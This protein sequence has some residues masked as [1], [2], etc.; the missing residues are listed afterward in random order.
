LA[1]NPEQL[2]AV[3]LRE[4][5]VNLVAVP[6]SGKTSVFSKRAAALL[7][8]VGPRRFLGVT[9]TKSAAEEFEHR[10]GYRSDPQNGKP[11]VFRTFHGF[12]LEVASKEF[13]NFPFTVQSHPLLLPHDQY[14][15]LGPVLKQMNRRR[16]YKEVQSYISQCKRLNISPEQA[17]EDAEGDDAVDYAHAYERYE[18][19]CMAMGKF[20]FDSLLIHTVKLLESRPEILARWQPDFL[21]C[22]EAQDNDALQW[23]LVELLGAK[24]NVFVVGDPN[25]NMYTWRG[26]DALGLTE[27]FSERWPGAK[28]LSLS[29]NYRSTGA[30]VDYLKEIAPIKTA[31]VMSMTS[32]NEQ[33]M[34]PT[35]KRYASE[36][37]EAEMI[38]SGLADPEHTAILARTNRQLGE[39]EKA[40][41]NLDLKYKLLGRSGFFSQAEVEF[42]LAFAQYCAGAATDDSVKKIIRSPFEVVR[43]LKKHETLERLQELQAG[44]IGHIPYARLLRQYTGDNEGLV[45]ELHRQ[46]NEARLA[47]QGKPSQDALRNILTRFGI[48]HHYEDD[49]DAIDNNPGDNIM[50]LLR[51]AERKATLLDFVQMCHK[52]KQASRSTSKRLTFST[53][54]QAKGLEWKWVYV[55]G[56]NN[57]ILP[58]KNGELEEEKRIY[59]VACSRAEKHLQVSCNDIPSP[60]IKGVLPAHLEQAVEVDMLHTMYQNALESTQ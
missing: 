12:A 39:F 17:I 30:I 49:E 4:G 6:G 23:R 50:S 54:H 53:V 32:A 38:L 41:G 33:G 47:V 60:F 8:E 24:G 58:H 3:D 15:I 25:Q 1:L 45:H 48:M 22:D 57:D 44:Q 40:A 11:K 31:A 13:H 7:E 26:S 55:I 59:F 5:P 52:A 56:V 20:D 18:S 21:Q 27:K 37:Q 42:T 28:T 35:F 10:A 36:A 9:F 43:F 19:K 29:T 16:K 14:K 51:M 2:A 46:L 34:A